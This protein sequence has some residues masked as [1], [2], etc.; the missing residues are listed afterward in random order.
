MRGEI[1]PVE[2]AYARAYGELTP[3]EIETP[4]PNR[5]GLLERVDKFLDKICDDG[6]SQADS[7]KAAADYAEALA[8][9]TKTLNELLSTPTVIRR[10]RGEE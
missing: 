9:Y 3:Q 8:D 4:A 10:L 5:R 7:L 6:P 1:I 2:V